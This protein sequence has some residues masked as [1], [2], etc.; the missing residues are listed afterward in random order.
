M[1]GFR[2]SASR[3]ILKLRTFAVGLN[4]SKIVHQIKIENYKVS[5][6]ETSLFNKTRVARGFKLRLVFCEP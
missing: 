1:E 3:D 5:N 2:D 4:L 6:I